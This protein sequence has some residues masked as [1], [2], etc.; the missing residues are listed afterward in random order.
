MERKIELSKEELAALDGLIEQFNAQP[1][2]IPAVVAAVSAVVGA[3]AGVV[4]A[5]TAVVQAVKGG[6]AATDLDPLESITLDL[7][8]GKLSADD[9]IRL[10]SAAVQKK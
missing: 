4:A 9:L 3:G 2:G 5:V 7:F 6:R 8:Q 1:A 10:R